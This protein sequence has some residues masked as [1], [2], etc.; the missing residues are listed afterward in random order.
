MSKGTKENMFR[1]MNRRNK[2]SVLNRRRKSN[3]RIINT[4]VTDHFE[5]L[6]G[7]MNDEPL[8]KLNSGNCFDNEFVVL[9]SVVMEGNMRARIRINTGSGNNR[10]A[11]IAAN[12]LR[13]NRRIAVVGFGVDIETFTMILINSRFDFLERYT[14]LIVESIKQ[15]RTEGVAQERIVEVFDTFPRSDTP[16]GNF[17]DKNV[18]MRV[19]LK[20]ASEGVKNTDKARSKM[21]SFV[22]FSEHAKNDVADRMKKTVK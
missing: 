8:N 13:D 10:S 3:S 11:E 5:M 1:R 17:R 16:Y 15:S 21:L 18:N 22:E 12:V 9:M 7:D 4:V 20:A 6:I 2:A 14:E 19:P